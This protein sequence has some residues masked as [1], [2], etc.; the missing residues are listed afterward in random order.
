MNI[1]KNSRQIPSDKSYV[2]DNFYSDLVYGYLQVNSIM[3]K[4]GQY[5]VIKKSLCTATKLA[6]KLCI[7]RQTASKRLKYL[8]VNGFIELDKENKVYKIF[9][10]D[11]NKATL[12]PLDTVSFLVDVCNERVLTGLAVLIKYWY[13]NGAQPCDISIHYLKAIFGLSG[14]NRTESNKIVRHILEGLRDL[15]FI[16]FHCYSGGDGLKYRL[17]SVKN[18]REVSKC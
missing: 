9:P 10:I 2:S 7:S 14:T 17:D 3:S 8:E 5:R 18:K 11:G 12:L 15:G 1:E 4:K 6:G 16:K 13:Q